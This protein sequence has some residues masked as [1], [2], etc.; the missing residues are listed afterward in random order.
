MRNPLSEK[1]KVPRPILAVTLTYTPS[2]DR[3]QISRT[4]VSGDAVEALSSTSFGCA[5]AVFLE[6]AI[7]VRGRPQERDTTQ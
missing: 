6:L 3:V 4:K 2:V 5:E 7:L 1:Q